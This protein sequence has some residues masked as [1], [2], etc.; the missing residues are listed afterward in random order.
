MRIMLALAG[1]AFAVLASAP[2]RAYD[3]CDGAMTFT[4]THNSA[5][6]SYG[7][8]SRDYIFADGTF[9]ADTADAFEQFL[10]QQ[11]PT[12]P[13][14][15]VVLNSPGGDLD[16]GM[17][18]GRSIRQHGFWTEVG[19][20][21]PIFIGVSPSV[22]K[23]V[24]PYLRRAI[25]PPFAGSCISAC[26]IA[27]LGGVFR[28]MDYGSEYGVHQWW[29]DQPPSDPAKLQWN[30]EAEEAKLVT[31]LKDMGIDPL[32][33]SEMSK[34]G[35]D[36]S[37]VVHLS[38]QQMIALKVVTPRWTTMSA[39]NQGNDGSYYLAFNT[40][41]PWGKQELD[42]SCYRPASG[43]PIVAATFYLDPGGR[44]KAEDIAPAIT[45]Y[46][47]EFD[48]G[49]VAPVADNLVLVK[50][51]AVS[52]RIVATLQ[53]APNWLTNSDMMSSAHIGLAVGGLSNTAKLPM[54]LLQFESD[55]DGSQLTKFAA[56]CK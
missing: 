48:E 3:K 29:S 15:I 56:P 24:V 43:S 52:G 22:P 32:W 8:G 7:E 5:G 46:A 47:I 23:Q 16:A 2:A 53:F 54:H 44:G 49:S 34:G 10:K 51:A 11:P 37:Q 41:D 12:D 38:M 55:F 4:L 30:T 31:Y 50:A 21:S 27:Y 1:V 13:H 40:L 19:A 28:F 33:L 26:T 14:A 39:L 6:E 45:K 35:R 20:A 9:C 25:T 42:F 17:A 36:F 18:L